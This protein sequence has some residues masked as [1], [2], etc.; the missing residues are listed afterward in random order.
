MAEVL[1]KDI[2]LVSSL[3][4]SCHFFPMRFL[5]WLRCINPSWES[6]VPTLTLSIWRWRCLFLLQSPNL[7]CSF[8]VERSIY[9]W[10]EFYKKK[11]FRRRGSSLPL[12]LSSS[13]QLVSK[14]CCKNPGKGQLDAL[15]APALAC[16]EHLAVTSNIS[17]LKNLLQW[18]AT[19]ES[20]CLNASLNRMLAN[21]SSE[22]HP[23]PTN[24]RC[25]LLPAPQGCS[26]AVFWVSSCHSIEMTTN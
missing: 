19:M 6:F 4:T 21:C 8:S 2:I 1:L 24:W 7:S 26:E 13:L 16:A 5:C 11:P 10:F 25:L 17:W 18:A 9:F 3:K 23:S 22:I 15:V 20:R 14:S 12:S